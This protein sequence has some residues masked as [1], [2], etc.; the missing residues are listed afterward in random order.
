M[1]PQRI[2]LTGVGGFVGGHLLPAL[3]A[4]F[5]AADL[6]T[7]PAAFDIADPAAVDALIRAHRPSVCIHLAAIAA[8]TA[9]RDDPGRAWQ[10]NLHGTLALARAI[11][12]H[13]PACVLLF[14]SS[15]EIYGRSFGS[16]AKL[17]EAAAAAPMNLYAATKAA[18]DLAL[19]AMAGDGLRSIRL[20]AFNHTGPGQSASFV[21]PAFA[22]QVAAIAAGRQPAVLHVGALDPQRDFLDVRDVCRAYVAC[23]ERAGSLPPGRVFNIASGTP[24]RIG[25]ILARLIAIAGVAAEVRTNADLLRPSEIPVAVGDASLAGAE[26]GWSPQIPWE[27]TLADVYADWVGRDRI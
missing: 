24:R 7:G 3:R 21:V 1:S 16:G 19:G 14:A 5:P 2:L 27:T 20:R 12:A 6:L 11:M 15:A 23:I 4:A 25:D 9:A 18:A 13:A 8:V 10:V 17:T 22:R 26:L